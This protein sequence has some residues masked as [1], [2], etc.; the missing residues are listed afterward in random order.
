M[1]LVAIILGTVLGLVCTT[2]LLAQPRPESKPDVRDPISDAADMMATRYGMLILCTYD[3]LN[4]NDYAMIIANQHF[5]RERCIALY[6]GAGN[7]NK[8]ADIEDF[9]SL[10]GAFP[11]IAVDSDDAFSFHTK[12]KSL[13]FRTFRE[14]AT[15]QLQRKELA[16]DR[17][18]NNPHEGLIHAGIPDSELDPKSAIAIVNA[19]TKLNQALTVELARMMASEQIL[20]LAART[21][22]YQKTE[23]AVEIRMNHRVTENRI[24]FVVAASTLLKSASNK[25]LEA[26]R[27]TVREIF[28]NVIKANPKSAD[29]L[30][31]AAEL[32][33]TF[34]D[35][36][37]MRSRKALEK[38][39]FEQEKKASKK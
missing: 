9:R 22:Q 31:H 20:R 12:M 14:R 5:A 2:T 25:E 23:N 34:S 36:A 7:E 27:K 35:E 17:T 30:R 28:L 11:V 4:V 15:L 8:K 13:K 18:R 21:N 33:K 37:L 1:R 24:E 26:S 10:K 16:E 29:A 19:E 3:E 32:S 39:L 38:A 6:L